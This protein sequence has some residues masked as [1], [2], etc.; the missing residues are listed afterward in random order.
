MLLEHVKTNYL[1]R[2]VNSI[3]LRVFVA[4]TV[5]LQIIDTNEP[6]FLPL[7]Q[8]SNWHHQL[9]FACLNP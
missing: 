9:G 2:H 5:K 7:K 6:D 4:A 8:V 1:R 3:A